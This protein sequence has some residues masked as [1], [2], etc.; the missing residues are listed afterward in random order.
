MNKKELIEA[1]NKTPKEERELKKQ[2]GKI[3]VLEVKEEKK[4]KKVKWY[5]AKDFTKEELK[6]YKGTGKFYIGA[7]EYAEIDD[8]DDED[9]YMHITNAAMCDLAFKKPRRKPEDFRNNSEYMLYDATLYDAVTRIE[10][11]YGDQV[12]G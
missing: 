6:Y 10:L 12:L 9:N 11:G 7:K 4:V 5:K 1:I 8:C 2:R 3:E